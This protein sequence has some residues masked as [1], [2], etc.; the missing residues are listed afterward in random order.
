MNKKPLIKDAIEYFNKDWNWIM[1]YHDK[2]T[3]LIIDKLVNVNCLR[4]CLANHKINEYVQYDFHD[5]MYFYP[6]KRIED[7]HTAPCNTYM[8]YE[9]IRNLIRYHWEEES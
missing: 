9:E 8:T 2:A 4:L 7:I 3:G 5:L 6:A 1:I